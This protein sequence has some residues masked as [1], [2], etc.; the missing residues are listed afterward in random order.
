MLREKGPV[1]VTLLAC[2]TI[3]NEKTGGV[4]TIRIMDVL[5]V[6]SLSMGARFFVL[7]YLHSRTVDFGQH[8]AKLNMLGF[9]NGNWSVVA[10]A[11]AYTFTYSYAATPNAPGAFMLTTEF[12]LDLRTFGELG[13]F[14]VQLAV[15]GDLLEQ[16]PITLRRG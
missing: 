6:G 8:V 3:L 7:T 16:T 10:D 11:P 15:D 2:E 13:T 12:N 4:S 5:T 14:W 9:R 1:S